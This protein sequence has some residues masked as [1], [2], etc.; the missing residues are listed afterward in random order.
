M[1]VY[2]ITIIEILCCSNFIHFYFEG[3]SLTRQVCVVFSGCSPVADLSCVTPPLRLV[4]V[5]V[6][7]FD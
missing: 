2:S 1:D 5:W 3:P 4:T 7:S 6:R